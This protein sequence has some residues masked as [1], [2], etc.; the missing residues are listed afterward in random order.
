M[1]SAS[2]QHKWLDWLL[3]CMSMVVATTT[4]HFLASNMWGDWAATGPRGT[5]CHTFRW[6]FLFSSR[7]THCNSAWGKIKNVT[8]D[9][10]VSPTEQRRSRPTSSSDQQ[11]RRGRCHPGSR[12]STTALPP[13]GKWSCV[14]SLWT[15]S[16][17]GSMELCHLVS[18]MCLFHSPGSTGGPGRLSAVR[19]GVDGVAISEAADT[20]QWHHYP[21][22]SH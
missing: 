8:C 9:F 19:S 21:G 5:P 14:I 1:S 22:T 12:S 2:R 3:Q 20:D 11:H 7:A 18:L 17:F 6:Y 15:A 10:L 16:S 4:W 13:T